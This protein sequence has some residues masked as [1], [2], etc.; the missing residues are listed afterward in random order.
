MNIRE[1]ISSAFSL[2]SLP[3]LPKSAIDEE[4]REIHAGRC[5]APQQYISFVHDL[6]K[7][8]GDDTQEPGY[9]RF[10]KPALRVYNPDNYE[11]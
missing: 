8:V 7:A 6:R 5:M 11:L 3:P 9:N 4:S 2:F 1:I 10:S